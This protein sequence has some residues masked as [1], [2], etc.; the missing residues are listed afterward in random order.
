MSFTNPPN[1]IFITVYHGQ[2]ESND[3]KSSRKKQLDEIS[4]LEGTNESPY[5]KR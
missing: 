4:L 3:T 1:Y 2:N 5:G